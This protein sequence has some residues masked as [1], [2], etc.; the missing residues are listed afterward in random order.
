M[1]DTI[2]IGAGTAGLTASI[3]ALRMGMKVLMLEKSTYGGQIINSS[4]VEN[5][6][7]FKSIDGFEFSTKLYEQAKAL[8]LEIKFNEV[9]NIEDGNIKKVITKNE[10]IETKTIILATGLQKR[11]LGLEN[12]DKLTGK[13]ISYCATCDGY[14]YKE[15]IV[16]MVGGGNT[17]LEEVLYLSNYCTKVYL[18]N[19]SGSFRADQSLVERVLE[20]E[21]VEILYDSQ[22]TKI[23]GEEKLES[24]LVNDKEFKIDGLF[25]AIGQIPQN[26]IFKD[27]I[28]LNEYGYIK[29]LEDCKTNID[30]I[31]VAGDC[32]TKKVRQ[33]VTAASDGAV[34]AIEAFEYIK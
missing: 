21:N 13:G 11:K 14:F 2:I 24:I 22:V 9:V 19:R 33:L 30:G 25:I 7:G 4:E 29:A 31:Y 17:A 5:F 16:A 10:I 3:Y 23:V 8:G 12:E 18:I 34:A 32:R 27:L 6:P 28:N 15:K 20:K 26:E 1:Y